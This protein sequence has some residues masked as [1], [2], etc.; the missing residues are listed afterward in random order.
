MRC[1]QCGFEIPKNRLNCPNCDFYI[2]DDPDYTR[3]ENLTKKIIIIS[4]ITFFVIVFCWHKVMTTPPVKINLLG[5]GLS[6]KM[7]YQ[8]LKRCV[9]VEGTVLSCGAKTKREKCGVSFSDYLKMKKNF[10]N[11]M[12]AFA[13]YLK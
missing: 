8:P 1:K 7:K 9:V 3:K 2:Y 6:I 5:S 13:S 12:E 11:N 10:K 4:V